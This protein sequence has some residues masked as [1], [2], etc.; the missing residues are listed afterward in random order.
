VNSLLKWGVSGLFSRV[1]AAIVADY[2]VSMQ[3]EA[4]NV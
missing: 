2:I 4:S 1:V 3:G